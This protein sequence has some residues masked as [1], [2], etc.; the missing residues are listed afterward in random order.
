MGLG[1]VPATEKLMAGAEVSIA[2]VGAIE[3]NEAFA[4]QSV[5]VIRR[6]KLDENK[7][8]ADG[9]ATVLGH[10]LGRSG[11]RL[12][13]TLLGR[14]EREGAPGPGDL[15]RRC[16]SG[17]PRCSWRQCE[18]PADRGVSRTGWVVITL[19]RPEARNAINAAMIGELHNACTIGCPARS[20]W[21]VAGHCRA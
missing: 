13:V 3:V 18:H 20:G 6:L 21:Q 8:N 5:A 17:S 10:P 12:L 16:R 14:M 11:V 4:A 19:D 9:G 15:V 2:D 7:V 1:P